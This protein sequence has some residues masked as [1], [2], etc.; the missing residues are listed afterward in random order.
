MTV[1]IKGCYIICLS[2]A[3]KSA[4]ERSAEELKNSDHIT[5]S[6]GSPLYISE[7][8]NGQIKLYLNGVV[9]FGNKMTTFSAETVT[10]DQSDTPSDFDFNLCQKRVAECT[11]LK[12]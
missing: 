3:L 4:G 2:S 8:K 12:T 6:D 7:L 10:T 5:F 1:V 9:N 11:K